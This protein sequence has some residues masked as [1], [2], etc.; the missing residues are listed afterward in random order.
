MRCPSLALLLRLAQAPL[1]QAWRR[2]AL[3]GLAVGLSAWPLEPWAEGLQRLSADL[4]PG[5]AAQAV[6]LLGRLPDGQQRLRQR[7]P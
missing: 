2:A 5:L 4:D 6:D 3:E 7:A 1:P